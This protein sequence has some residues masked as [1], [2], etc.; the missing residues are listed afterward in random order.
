M[1]PIVVLPQPDSPTSP[2]VDP[3]G[4]CK[5]DARDGVHRGHASLQDARGHR[6]LLH[7]VAQLEED[8]AHRPACDC[9]L[10]VASWPTG[11]THA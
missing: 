7:D 1:R 10:T 4:T 6:V 5:R 3:S 2:N 8:L 11:C 9:V